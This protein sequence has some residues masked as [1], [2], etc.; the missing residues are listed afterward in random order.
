[1]NKSQ[2]VV[3]GIVLIL[4]GVVTLL[5]M[6]TTIEYAATREVVWR[7]GS[8]VYEVV[9][10]LPNSTAWLACLLGIVFI[11]AGIFVLIS[12]KRR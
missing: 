6:T 11:G 2:R 5:F 12:K 9:D 10:I 7:S 4:M 1:M 3:A 8:R